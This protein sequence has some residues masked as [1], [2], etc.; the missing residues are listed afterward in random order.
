MTQLMHV[1]L[2][3]LRKRMMTWVLAALMVG[4][5]V[6][7]YSVLWSVSERVARFGE[8]NEFS[9]EQLRRALFVQG[10][11]PYALQIIGTLGT[12]LA[13]IL[14]AGAAGSEYAWGTVRLMATASSGRIRLILSKLAVVFALTVAGVILG[15]VVAVVYS[16]II[17][18]VS[19]GADYGFVDG[20]FVRDQA[21]AF[22]RT[23]FVMA[24]YITLAFA[25]AIVGRSTLA[26]VGAGLGVA[27]IEPLISGLMRAGGSPWH[28]VPNYLIGANIDVISAQNK[29]DEVLPRFG[30]SASELVRRDVN[31][32]EVA[33]LVIGIYIAVF[34]AIALIA[35]RR[36]DI[37]AGAG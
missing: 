5:I 9:A 2:F 24:P 1:E 21:L 31:S 29:I 35:Y 25:A 12:L 14:A 8:H 13:I 23:L 17:T 36:R 4:L 16:A 15:I 27:F 10:S 11:I 33:F 7:L 22:G 6:L 26:G 34:I 18:Y 20:A 28:N 3:K 37:T 30:P 19:G 32:V